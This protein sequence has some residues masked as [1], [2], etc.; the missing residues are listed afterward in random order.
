MMWIVTWEEWQIPCSKSF[1]SL[2]EANRWIAQLSELA[3]ATRIRLLTAT[4]T[5]SAKASDG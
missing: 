4:V 5:D 2:G 3:S 1:S